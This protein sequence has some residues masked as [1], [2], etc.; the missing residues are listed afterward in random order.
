MGDKPLPDIRKIEAFLRE[1]RVKMRVFD[2]AFR[3]RDKNLATLLE[4][5]LTPNQRLEILRALTVEDCFSGPNEDEHQP[6]RPDYFEFGLMVKGRVV[7]VKLSLG[8]PGKMVD[9]MSFHIAEFP[10]QYPFKS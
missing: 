7:Y 5:D 4:L 10:I 6:G 9:C 3:P 2:V 8:L 1:L